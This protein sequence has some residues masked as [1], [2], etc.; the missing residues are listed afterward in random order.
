[1]RNVT[2]LVVVAFGVLPMTP[3]SALPSGP[4]DIDAQAAICQASLGTSQETVRSL[5]NSYASTAEDRTKLGQRCILWTYGGADAAAFQAH[6][7]YSP[8]THDLSSK[9][10]VIRKAAEHAVLCHS[11]QEADISDDRHTDTLESYI[12]GSALTLD[13]KLDLVADCTLY[14]MGY[15]YSLQHPE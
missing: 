14:G 5:S 3:T 9:S 12:N 2:V 15:L 13:E 7:S 4:T 8:P 6:K 10:P 1:M 11:F